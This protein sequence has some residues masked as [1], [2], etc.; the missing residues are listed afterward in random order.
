MSRT[1]W[2]IVVGGCLRSGTSLIRRILNAHSRIHCGPEVKF[3]RDFYGDYL[4]D[5]LSH[6]RFTSTARAILAETELLEVLGGAFV[7]MHERAMNA[8]G[9]ARWADKTPE[10]VL[11]LSEWEK[12]LG[13]RWLFVHVVRNPLDTLASIKEAR[14]PLT[15]PVDL[16]GR[17][18]LYRE[19]TEAGLRFAASHPERAQIL[20]Y[21]RL[22]DAPESGVRGLMSWLGERFE[23]S[24]LAFNEVDHGAGLEDP[25][26]A[27]TSRVHTSSVHRWP[28]ILSDDEALAV[29]SAT[30]DLWTQIDPDRLYFQPPSRVVGPH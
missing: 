4:D 10:N 28:T 6:L 26:V 13:D 5:P 22:A 14:F 24:Q 19:Y 9:K 3:F 2:P 18:A 23:P 1:S 7:S 8:A 30:A 17:I 12:L 15:L 25:K 16:E 11:Y 29:W 27:T 20:V 21:E